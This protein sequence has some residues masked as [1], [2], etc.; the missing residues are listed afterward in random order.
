MKSLNSY[1]NES[2]FN[3]N[4]LQS[5]LVLIAG[6]FN[7]GGEGYE[8]VVTDRFGTHTNYSFTVNL[9][10]NGAGKIEVN[11]TEII[12]RSIGHIIEGVIT[13]A[14]A[15]TFTL[16]FDDKNIAS[17]NFSLKPNKNGNDGYDFEIVDNEGNWGSAKF[18][19][20]AVRSAGT[21]KDMQK[22]KNSVTMSNNE[23]AQCDF[24]LI[25]E[26]VLEGNT[27]HIPAMHIVDKSLTPISVS[28]RSHLTNDQIE[29]AITFIGNKY[30]KM[31]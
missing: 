12:R 9:D 10:V 30:G 28:K 23:K 1:I 13:S 20:K 26:Y 6:K 2:L 11:D 29:K 4:M 3:D 16:N 21:E 25:V 17:Q 8:N 14:L 24:F 22:M 15:G 27:V 18:D 7:K 19:V 31:Q 5:L